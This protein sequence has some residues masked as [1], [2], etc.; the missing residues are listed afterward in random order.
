MSTWIHNVPARIERWKIFF[1]I[2]ILLKNFN[3]WMVS[4]WLSVVIIVFMLS[5][6]SD[7]FILLLV[8][9][10]EALEIIWLSLKLSRRK[11]QLLLEWVIAS[12]VCSWSPGQLL[13]ALTWVKS[14]YSTRWFYEVHVLLRMICLLWKFVRIRIIYI[15]VGLL[16]INLIMTFYYIYL[17]Y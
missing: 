7:F 6:A 16:H 5:W 8:L 15:S 13:H 11:W 14:L 9:C 1:W 2:D 4:R 17:K 3:T 12:D 10:V